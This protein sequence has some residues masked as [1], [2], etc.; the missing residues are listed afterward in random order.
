MDG[1]KKRAPPLGLTRGRR[2]QAIT[3]FRRLGVYAHVA[4]EMGVS[5]SQFRQWR[6]D[7]PDFQAALAEEKEELVWE[8]GQKSAH[9]LTE[10]LDSIGTMQV[11]HERDTRDHEG[12]PYTEVTRE[13]VRVHPGLLKFGLTKHDPDLVRVPLT[14]DER[15]EVRTFIQGVLA[16]R[17]EKAEAQVA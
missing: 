9:R 16:R 3:A 11:T 15:E 17:V 12:N 10:Y 1:K 7:H 5:V 8:I 6:R 14:K 2:E 13:V 4:N